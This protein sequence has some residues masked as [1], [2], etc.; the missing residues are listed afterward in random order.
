MNN[1]NNIKDIEPK[2]GTRVLCVSACKTAPVA[3]F[4]NCELGM[5]GQEDWYR[6]GDCTCDV[7]SLQYGWDY[8]SEPTHWMELP[9][10]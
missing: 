8:C 2:L 9:Q 4:V 1:W 6:E 7:E 10:K 3:I 5:P